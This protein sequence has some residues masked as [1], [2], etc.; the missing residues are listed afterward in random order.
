MF[1]M[2]SIGK[3]IS[4]ARKSNNMTQMELADKLNVSF[5][6]VSNWERGISMPDIAKLPDISS[7]IN[8]SIDELLGKDTGAIN[9][10]I[11]NNWDE[12]SKEQNIKGE[13]VADIIS[14][15][16][17]KQADDFFAENEELLSFREIEQVL[18]FLGVDICNKLFLKYMNQ[19]E[20]EQ[21]EI[22]APFV[23][24]ELI[25]QKVSQKIDEGSKVGNLVAFMDC[26]IR[27][28]MILK[29]YEG[30]GV[31]ALDDYIHFASKSVIGK[32]ALSE[33][34]K[35]KL[36]YFEHLAP[37]MEKKMLSDMVQNTIEKHGIIA[38]SHL[39]Q[40]LDKD[41]LKIFVNE[42]YL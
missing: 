2:T 34:D 30:K 41:I 15:L 16:K 11:S 19:N 10:V 18:P 40:F 27:D 36:R 31:Q 42:K 20:F 4:V 39:V 23:A 33:Y 25:N 9:A 3:K 14:I 22:I 32:I 37:F 6:S 28:Q 13:E 1:D 7:L 24:V 17:P 12:F 35:N 38:I 21:A 5:Q 8:L 26:A 29:I